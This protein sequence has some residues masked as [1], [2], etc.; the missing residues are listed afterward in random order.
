MLRHTFRARLFAIAVAI[1]ALGVVRVSNAG[2][3]SSFS[4]GFNDT[5]FLSDPAGWLPRVHAVGG[6]IVALDI[7][8]PVPHT[9]ER[10]VGFNARDPA[11]PQYAF[12]EADAAVRAVTASGLTPLLQFTGAPPWA[13]G[14]GRPATARAG[15]WRPDPAALHDY[16][17]ALARRYSGTFPDPLRPGAMLP[18]VRYFMP[19]NEPNLST[20]LAPQWVGTTPFAPGHYRRMLNAFTTG[21]K[22]VQPTDIVITA[23]TGPFGDPSPGGQRISPVRFW[24]EVLCLR[25]ASLRPAPCSDPARF[26]V[27]SHHPYSVGS[28]SRAALNADDA[29]IP[30]MRKLT[31]VL[32]RAESLDRVAPRAHKPLWVTEISYDSRPPDPRGVPLARHGHWV[33]ETLYQLW[34][35]GVSTVVWFRLGDDP[36]T[37]SYARTNQSGAFFADGRAKPAATAFRFPLVADRR[38]SSRVRVWTR[39]PTAGLLRIQNAA[40]QTLARRTVGAGAV[41]TFSIRLRGRVTLRALVGSERSLAYRTASRDG[42]AG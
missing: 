19:W 27:L 18:R 7:G 40:G 10:P 12:G 13:E 5:R 22:S 16:G 28:P 42:L 4:L 31:R 3:E 14:P 35:Q 24:R 29:S 1:A 36:P 17:E 26:D 39:A 20:F 9:P 30:D 38:S 2:A 21:V 33:E 41:A 37:P 11:A 32:R 25:S 34:R 23:G 6:E 8:W 15:S